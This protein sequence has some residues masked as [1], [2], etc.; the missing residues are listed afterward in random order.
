LLQ[1]G[2]AT[3]HR[4]RSAA[5]AVPSAVLIG[6]LHCQDRT[7]IGAKILPNLAISCSN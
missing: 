4:L 3:A 5:A 2:R 7:Q 6:T 1:L